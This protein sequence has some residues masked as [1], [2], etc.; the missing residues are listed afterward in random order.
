MSDAPVLK[1][2]H[3]NGIEFA[4]Y[5]QGTGALVLCIHGFPDTAETW[6]DVLPA[7]AN[8][9]Y[10]AVAPYTRGYPPTS[11]PA[12]ASYTARDLGNDVL[13][14]IEAL[15][16]QQAVVIGHDW[17][18]LAAYA[19]ATIDPSRI[20]K[21]VTVA[22]PHPLTLRFTPRVLWR[23]RHFITFQFR[24]MT[25]RRFRK[26]NFAFVD[27]IYR[28]WSPNWNFTAEDVQP[29]KTAFAQAG[30]LEAA[31]GYYWSFA[32]N[33]RN[34]EVRAVTARR[35]TVPTLSIFGE[36]DGAVDNGILPKTPKAFRAHYE[37]VVL[38]RAGHFPHR[39]APDSFIA[40]VLEFLKK[41][42]TE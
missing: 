20:S 35:T 30:G 33:L 25:L 15:G 22:I 4:Y 28:R 8:A 34:P 14:L 2:I 16:E 24:G 32:S 3:A 23:A 42:V 17:G 12:D 11:I 1:T 9:G 27:T 13:A 26:D 37:Y 6:R 19:A 7:L 31:L 41:E 39:E 10:R 5:E 40:H 18:A 21:L 38:P 29:V 36:A